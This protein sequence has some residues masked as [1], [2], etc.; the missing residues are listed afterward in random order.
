V[1][2]SRRAG[3]HV[4]A[5][6]VDRDCLFTLRSQGLTLDSKP[7]EGRVV[8]ARSM[9]G[10]V[11]KRAEVRTVYTDAVAE[12][13]CES[14]RRDAEEAARLVGSDFLGVDV[15]TLDPTVPLRDAGGVINE[16]NTTP[17]LHHHYDPNRELYPAVARPIVRALLRRQAAGVAPD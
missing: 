14:I 4:H 3:A 11:R 12:L 8:L 6:E 1:K 2:N 7:E 13:I 10:K 17:A 16:V 5:V 15:I 9:D